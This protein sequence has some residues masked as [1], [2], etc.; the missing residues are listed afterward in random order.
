MVAGDVGVRLRARRGLRLR[1]ARLALVTASVVIAS[2]ALLPLVFLILQA[3]QVGSHALSTVLWRHLTVTLLWNTIRLTVLVT[4]ASAAIGVAAAWCTERTDLPLRRVWT[5]LLVLPLAVPDFVLG[6]GWNA[7]APSVYGFWGSVLV[8]TTG[9]YPLVY[10][11]VAAALRSADPDLEDIART[12][13]GRR[14]F[15]F[16]RTVLQQIR[17]ALLGGCLVVSLILLAEFGTFEIL[18]FQTFS[19]EIFTEFEIGFNTPAACALSLVLVAL[20]LCLLAGEAAARGT[21][22]PRRGLGRP[23]RRA[24]LG[25]GAPFVLAGLAAL[26]GLAIGVPLWAIVYWFARGSSSTLPAASLG[27]AAAATAAYCASAAAIAT[28]AA[29]P[30]ALLVERRRARLSLLLE[31]ST[32]IVLALPGLV[33]ALALGYFTV[34]YLPSLYQSNGELVFT[35]AVMFFPL[36]LVV[37]RGSAAQASTALEDVA[38]TLGHGRLSVF[39]RVTLPLLLPG[40]LAAFALVFL[41][42]STELTATLLLHPTGVETLATQFWAYT[43]DFSYGAAAP[44]ALT[45]ML[46]AMVPGILL[47]YWFERIGGRGTS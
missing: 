46:V 8:M 2:A 21:V 31:R 26:V 15:A 30:V 45:L 34:R 44:Y 29:V 39:V 5:V 17:P 24:R 32:Y 11:P 12:L 20:G 37:L 23:P 10:L 6:F 43:S 27:H 7:L 25:W 42:A 3:V 16:A 36:A 38:R 13:G 40:L 19:T 4:I 41:I 33:V 47:G 9:S 1:P 18:R 35:Y 22:V 14:S 28:L